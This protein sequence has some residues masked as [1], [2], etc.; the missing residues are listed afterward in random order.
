MVTPCG[1]PIK[2]DVSDARRLSLAAL[3]I[4][5]KTVNLTIPSLI[6]KLLF[7]KIIK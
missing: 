4:L 2:T 3:S 5:E 7:A 6:N 1:M